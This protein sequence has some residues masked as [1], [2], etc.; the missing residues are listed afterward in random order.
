MAH[1]RA[2]AG[3][4]SG[5][6]RLVH[7]QCYGATAAGVSEIDAAFVQEHGLPTGGAKG[8]FDYPRG[9]TD[10][11]KAIDVFRQFIHLNQFLVFS[12]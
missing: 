12:F 8:L 2:P 5:D 9:A 10:I 3:T 1:I 4:P 7:V 11:G 6:K